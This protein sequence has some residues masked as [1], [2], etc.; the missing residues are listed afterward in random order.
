MNTLTLPPGK[1]Q[2]LLHFV[3]LGPRV[4]DATSAGV[5]A[6][7]EATA[8]SLAA[9]PEIGDLTTAEI[10]SIDNFN[11][12]ALTMNGFDYDSCS[13]AEGGVRSA[14][15]PV[16]KAEKPRDHRRRYDV[17][18]KTI[19]QLRADMERGVTTS[20]EI[21][22]AYLDR[23]AVYDQGQFGFNAYEI[24]ADRRDGAGP[25]RRR[26]PQERARRVRCSAFRSRSRTTTT[27]RTCRRPTAASRSTDS[28]PA[29]DAFQVA[30]LR[31]AGRGP[32][33]QG[34]T[35][36]VRHE[37]QLLE[38]RVGTGVER[39]QPVEVGARIERRLGQRGGGEPGRGGARIADRRLAVRA[40]RARRAW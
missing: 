18:E 25:G 10:C 2:S 22:R 24:V 29:R 32:D 37:R 23:I 7:V 35:G 28:V 36:G 1:S 20:Q 38:R 30:R 5:R 26:R 31:E 16:P 39:V 40:R 33:R 12:A 34:G 11:I 13:E 27:P 17:V 21:T 4:T 6:A 19:G 14:Q 9:A 15:A 8:S 3:V